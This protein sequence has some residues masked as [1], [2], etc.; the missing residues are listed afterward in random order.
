LTAAAVALTLGWAGV[1]RDAP[2]D[3]LR[4][5]AACA[6]EI[7]TPYLIS[8]SGQRV[9]FDAI[10]PV[11][12]RWY[13]PQDLYR[14]YK[15]RA[16][17]YSNYARDIYQ[18]YTDIE[19]EGERWY[20]IYGNYITRGWQIYDWRQEQPLTFG[21]AILK[22]PQ[23]SRWFSNLVIASDSKGEHF[24]TITIG[25]EIRTTLTPLTFSKPAYSGMQWDYLSDKYAATVL[26]SRAN[27][28]GFAQALDMVYD[29]TDFTNLVGFRGTAQ[30]G[31]YATVGATYVN[32]YIGRTD[33][34]LMLGDMRKGQLSTVQNGDVVRWVAIRVADDSPADGRAGGAYF[35]STLWTRRVDADGAVIKEWGP[36]G[37]QPVIDGGYQKR[38]YLAADGAEEI[39]LTYTIVD[40]GLVDRIGFDL[41]LSNDY[42]VEVASN[43]QT[44]AE[45]FPVYLLVARAPQNVDD[46]SNQRVVHFEYG[47]PTANE[48]YGVTLEVHDVW[49]I[50]L[51]G[52]YD[53]NQRYRRFPNVN[54]TEHKATTDRAEAYYLTATKLA[55]PWFA[56]AEAFGL[57][58]DYSTTA[59]MVDSA[60]LLDYE[61]DVKYLYELVDD[62]DDQDRLPDWSRQNQRSDDNGVFPGLD[63]NNDYRSDYNQND[64]VRPDYEEPFLRYSVS[65]PEFLFGIDMNHN[66]V[67][68]RFEDDDEPDF[69]YRRGHRGYNGYVGLQMTPEMKLRVGHQREWTW[70]DDRESRGNYALFTLDMDHPRL[71]S[72]QVYEHLQLVE[73]DLPDDVWIWTQPRGTKGGRQL[74][75]DPLRARDA[76]INTAYLGLDHRGARRLN[77]AHKL[78]LETYRQR[79]HAVPTWVDGKQDTLAA[80]D[81]WSLAVANQVDYSFSLGGVATITPQAKSMYLQQQTG[82]E[83]ETKELTEAQF[84]IMRFPVLTRSNLEFGVEATQFW[85]F[86]DKYN[87]YDGLVLACQF[88]NRSSY[89]GYALTTH[90]G[91]QYERKVFIRKTERSTTA[92]VSVFAGLGG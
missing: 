32:A 50:S 21:S 46:N 71:G 26:A 57:D 4:S 33:R 63:E 75:R 82:G 53:T 61:D 70:D 72:L 47:L 17:D 92:F 14:Q 36:E 45:G 38:G 64:N 49:G 42:R 77:T 91:L 40:P 10:D 60:G 66:T 25:D 29:E 16:W 85:D 48:I 18:R 6:Q 87:D 51:R 78:K 19:L 8:I 86:N 65:P 28:P 41:V 55:W 68:D 30:V 3:L 5:S 34:K 31:D 13:L 90:V 15:W 44:D 11:I 2:L 84:L 62:N 39:T 43:L 76:I 73:D 27:S 80:E 79:Q 37:A 89:Q 1:D 81:S 23:Y 52:E 56:Y 58:D 67:I 35:S 74:F 69:P 24:T 59:Y 83:N 88:A 12:R 7:T 22:Q 9:V 54:F 20:D